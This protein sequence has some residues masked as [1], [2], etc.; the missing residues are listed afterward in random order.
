MKGTIYKIT[1]PNTDKIYI[2]S[3]TR[4]INRRYGQHMTTYRAF[5]KGNKKYCTSIEIIKCGDSRIEMIEVVEGTKQ[6]IHTRERYYIELH[7]GNCINKVIPT[8]TNAEYK[9]CNKNIIRE[10]TYREANR[11]KK[12]EQSKQYR[13][14]NRDKIR[15][16]TKQYR[17]ANRDKKREQDKQYYE[18]NK[19]EIMKQRKEQCECECGTKYSRHCKA[20]H[21]KSQ[22]HINYIT[23]NITINGPNAIINNMTETK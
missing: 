21:L 18:R 13:D 14:A 11:E 19:N 4:T 12:R 10:Q 2:G 7:N 9:H 20:R 6:E 23:I 15:E 8:R 17:E 16:Q 1:S 3:T 22:K 5:M